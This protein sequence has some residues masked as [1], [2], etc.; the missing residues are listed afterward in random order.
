L[1]VSVKHHHDAHGL[2]LARDID[3]APLFD[4]EEEVYGPVAGVS[5]TAGG[6]E[7]GKEKGEG[8]AGTG[9]FGP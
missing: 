7:A 8:G 6:I 1:S 5:T 4:V 9:V 2:S 3:V